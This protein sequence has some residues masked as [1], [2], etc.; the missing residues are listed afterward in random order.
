MAR[1]KGSK[2]KSKKHPIDIPELLE[3]QIEQNALEEQS[4]KVAVL[5]LGRKYEATGNTFEECINKIKFFGTKAVGVIT[6]TKGDY[7]TERILNGRQMHGLFGGGSP[8][9]KMIHIKQAKARLG[10]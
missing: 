7:T 9:L 3:T 8:T 2:N 5:S 1:K 10:L 4:L 6:V